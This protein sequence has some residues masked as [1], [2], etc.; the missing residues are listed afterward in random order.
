[1]EPSC[2]WICNPPIVWLGEVAVGKILD[3]IE[4]PTRCPRFDPV[5]GSN[6]HPL[7]GPLSVMIIAEY[8][9]VVICRWSDYH[10]VAFGDQGRNTD[11]N[12]VT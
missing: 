5:F 6:N 1:M 4:K 2:G 10:G 12:R 11:F 8:S 7:F 9:I 3:R